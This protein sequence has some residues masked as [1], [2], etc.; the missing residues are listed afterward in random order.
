MN[1]GS[2]LIIIIDLFKKL[3]TIWSSI[4]LLNFSLGPLPNVIYKLSILCFG[5]FIPVFD[6]LIYPLYDDLG[7]NCTYFS[8]YLWF[9]LCIMLCMVCCVNINIFYWSNYDYTNRVWLSK[10][11]NIV[12]AWQIQ[13]FFIAISRIF[14]SIT[15][16][17]NAF[18]K[19]L[20]RWIFC[21]VTFLFTSAMVCSEFCTCTVTVNRISYGCM[22]PAIEALL[23]YFIFLLFFEI[24]RR[25][26]FSTIVK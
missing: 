23:W 3:I 17:D 16:L 9:Y 15:G 2:H 11:N 4:I 10:F 14:A 20:H 19:H 25:Y 6:T 24:L 13:L 18:T 26:M 21:Y 22:Q 12:V 5:I 1:V 7:L 8:Y